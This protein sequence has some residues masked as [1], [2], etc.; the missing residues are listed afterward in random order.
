[1][2]ILGLSQ[3]LVEGVIN[4]LCATIY[5]NDK[6]RRFNMLH[7]WWPAG[8]IIGGLL[9]FAVTKILALD[10]HPSAAIATLGWKIKMSLVL[11]AAGTFAVLIFGQSFPPTE[12]VA[13]GIS[14]RD[15]V[16][17]I[18]KPMFLVWFALMWLTASTE[19]GPDQWIGSVITNLTGMQGI[20]VLVYTSGVVFLLRFFGGGLAHKLSPLRLLIVA[21]MLACVGLLGLSTSKSML[22]L[23]AAATAFGA[24]TSYFWPV[25]LGVTSER[26]PQT[27][28]AGLAIMGGTGQLAAAFIL[29]MMG[30]WYDLWGPASAFQLVAILPAVLTLAFTILFLRYRAMGGYKP[31][32]LNSSEWSR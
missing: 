13:A 2:L 8:L 26:F 10:S 1:M 5:A 16:K 18:F 3:G 24:G 14:N 4:P 31:L 20:L 12:R 29:P 30:R 25:M 19:L 15:M 9:A 17:A 32:T 27:G 21:A 6:T 28:P 22:G 7:A 11:F 23:F